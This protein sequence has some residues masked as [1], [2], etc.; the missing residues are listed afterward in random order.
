MINEIDTITRSADGTTADQQLEFVELV[1]AANASLDGWS[2]ALFDA[3]DDSAYDVFDLTSFTTDG[4]GFFVVG[5]PAVDN[6]SSLQFADDSMA[7]L[8]FEDLLNG[9]HAVALY[10]SIFPNGGAATTTD[11]ED[12]IV[13][14]QNIFQSDD[15]FLTAFGLDPMDDSNYFNEGANGDADNESLS[16]APDMSGAFVL[17]APT[18]GASNVAAIPEPGSLALLAICSLPL[19]QRRRVAVRNA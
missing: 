18:P 9:L 14:R 11:L 17:Q 4:S 1:G 16:R 8:P 12:V 13:Y 5:D 2:L 19:L 10:S 3:V 6:V 7:P 15:D